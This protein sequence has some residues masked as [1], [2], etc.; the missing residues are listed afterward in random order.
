[1]ETMRTGDVYRIMEDDSHLPV[2]VSQE[3]LD[4]LLATLGRAARLMYVCVTD[5]PDD[6][7]GAIRRIIRRALSSAGLEGREECF[8]FLADELAELQE[9][10]AHDDDVPPYEECETIFDAGFDTDEY[11]RDTGIYRRMVEDGEEQEVAEEVI[12]RGDETLYRK[13]V[14][15]W[16]VVPGGRHSRSITYETLPIDD[17]MARLIRNTTRSRDVDRFA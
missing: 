16:E 11:G 12:L 13:R 9:Q 2:E 14:I 17:D 7:D 5:F 4:S 10:L 1:M 8:S 6:P 15:V 3:T